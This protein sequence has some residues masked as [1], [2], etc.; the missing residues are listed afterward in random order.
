M[1]E[2]SNEFKAQFEKYIF[3]VINSVIASAS[4]ELQT[5]LINLF[6]KVNERKQEQVSLPDTPSP[7]PSTEWHQI[8]ARPV[9][10]RSMER[11]RLIILNKQQIVQMKAHIFRL[12]SAI[13]QVEKRAAQNQ[14]RFSSEITRFRIRA[15]EQHILTQMKERL[16]TTNQNLTWNEN[17]LI[18]LHHPNK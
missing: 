18:R 11:Q 12:E 8:L 14:A 1:D 4:P 6:N 2:L 9:D 13:D 17:L 7:E 10:Y 15:M 16:V 3:S 5:K